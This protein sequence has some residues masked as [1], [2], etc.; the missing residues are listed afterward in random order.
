MHGQ[1]DAQGGACL[2]SKNAVAKCY[3][4]MLRRHATALTREPFDAA[5]S[6]VARH[7]Q[8]QRKAV[9]GRQTLAVA[10]KR[11]QHLQ[12]V[13]RAVQA[14]HACTQRGGN[15]V[16]PFEGDIAFFHGTLFTQDI[17][18]ERGSSQDAWREQSLMPRHHHPRYP[19]QN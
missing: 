2:R 14:A 11:Q 9:V 16:L 3:C 17:K 19:T 7:H 1:V 6:D 15:E 8:A 4:R 13:Q 5:P 10:L 12:C 18:A